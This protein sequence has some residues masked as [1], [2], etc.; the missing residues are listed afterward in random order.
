MIGRIKKKILH[1]S[2]FPQISF[3]CSSSPILVSPHSLLLL[4]LYI[5]FVLEVNFLKWFFFI[6]SSNFESYLTV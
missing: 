2:L 3:T 6:L 5:S 4:L 1:F